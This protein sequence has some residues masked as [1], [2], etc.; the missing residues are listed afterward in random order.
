MAQ[1]RAIVALAGYNCLSWLLGFN[2]AQ[3]IHNSNIISKP[4][5]DLMYIQ[6]DMCS[7]I[8]FT[9]RMFRSIVV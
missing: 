2:L 1:L 3:Y 9:Y 7:S 8:N 4:I 5:I 6:M